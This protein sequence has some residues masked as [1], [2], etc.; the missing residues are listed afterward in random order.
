MVFDFPAP[1]LA[2]IHQAYRTPTRAYHAWSH[3]EEVEQWYQ[4]VSK[5]PGWKQPREVFLAVL[6]HDA[7][8]VAGRKDNEAKS[9]QLATHLVGKHIPNQ[10]LDTDR[11]AELI[12]LTAR[13]GAL[14]PKDV[15]ADAAHFLDCDMAILGSAPEVFDRYDAA[16]REEYWEVP[17]VLYALGRRRFL[18]RL[19]A[20]PR[21]FLS[22]YFHNRLDAAAR[23]NLRRVLGAA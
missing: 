23:A 12:L 6:M 22:D 11:V 13:H 7:V 3:I 17:S 14:S 20:A 2:A 9:A 19:L 5:G 8:Y 16:I 10:Q 1:M 21:I 18:T 4:E 15:D